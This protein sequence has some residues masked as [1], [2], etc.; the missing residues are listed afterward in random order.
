[1]RIDIDLSFKKHPI[2]KD[3]ATKKSSSAI[4][5]SLHNIVKT[6]FYE[7]GF[8]TQFGTNITAQLFEN[9]NDITLIGLKNN[10]E[11]AII[12]FEP[13]CE[14]IEVV[15]HEDGDNGLAC[16]IIYNEINKEET[17]TLIVQLNKLR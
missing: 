9:I 7:R 6:N 15:M 4:K 17:E 8:N 3:L 16:K 5:Q 1:M 13:G 11:T 2:T 12:N 10:I 14:L